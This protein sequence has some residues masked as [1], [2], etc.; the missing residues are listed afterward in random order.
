MICHASKNQLELQLSIGFKAS[1]Q[2]KEFVLKMIMSLQRHAYEHIHTG[3]SKEMNSVCWRSVDV[4]AFTLGGG[5]GNDVL[6][7]GLERELRTRPGAGRQPGAGFGNLIF[8]RAP[9]FSD[10]ESGSPSPRSRSG[11]FSDSSSVTRSDSDT[12]HGRFW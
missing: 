2:G 1:P 6:L 3:G 5:I 11:S 8:N 10:D 4:L 9:S 12:G 7:D